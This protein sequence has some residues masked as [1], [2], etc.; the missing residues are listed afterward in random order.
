MVLFGPTGGLA[1]RKLVPALYNLARAGHLPAELGVVGYARSAG[2]DAAFRDELRAG[3]Q[4]FSRTGFDAE[5]W[6]AFAAGISSLRAG[7]DDPQGYL[8]LVERLDTLDRERGTAGNR[9]FYLATPPNATASIAT[10]LGAA[11]LVR[12]PD[13]RG[14]WTR[15]VVE[16]P[17]G[18]NLASAEALNHAVG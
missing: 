1:R 12:P 13:R 4:E 10:Q 11:A 7:Y 5:I 14:Q 17:F 15:V 18:P 2:E 16:N 9:L 6:G 3:V 8:R